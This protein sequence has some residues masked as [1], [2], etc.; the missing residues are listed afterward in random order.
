[1]REK[2]ERAHRGAPYLGKAKGLLRYPSATGRK[3]FGRGSNQKGIS[4][5]QHVKRRDIQGKKVVY[6]AKRRTAPNLGKGEDARRR[7]YEGGVGA[8][9]LKRTQTVAGPFWGKRDSR[10]WREKAS[11]S[12]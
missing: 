10:E 3:V 1:V 12:L 7:V 11:D 4:L 2:E 9:T 8:T 6:E 5:S